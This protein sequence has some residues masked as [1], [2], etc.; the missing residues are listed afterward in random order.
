MS[1]EPELEDDP[2]DWLVHADALQASG[3][4]RGELIAFNHALQSGATDDPRARDAFVRAHAQRLLGP[5]HRWGD[6]L[7]PQ[8]WWTSFSSAR[9]EFEASTRPG[10]VDALL[11]APQA[12]GLERL[13]IIGRA[14]PDKVLKH[15]YGMTRVEQGP[16]LNLAA[17]LE[18]LQQRGLPPGC[19]ELSL[20][21]DK[22]AR[23][24]FV[25][26]TYFDPPE[27]RVQFGDLRWLWPRC[28]QLCGLELVVSD[29]MQVELGTIHAPALEH[30][31]LECLTWNGNEEL[32]DSILNATWPKLRSFALR[33]PER[34]VGNIPDREEAYTRPYQGRKSQWH[35]PDEDG[36][37]LGFDWRP[38]VVALLQNLHSTRLKRLALTSFDSTRGVLAAIH[39]FGLPAGLEELDL[40]DS[41]LG[42]RD[43]EQMIQHEG[44]Y[45]S[46]KRLV[47]KRTSLSSQTA[48]L[49]SLMGPQVLHSQG[50]GAR[51]RFLVGAE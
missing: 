9:L 37:N 33:L 34:W 28:P 44:M 1:L 8:W 48:E 39:E 32:P 20:V 13:E 38:T 14:A 43:A 30:F 49:L 4:P 11:D 35:D 16:T 50:N 21:D 3:D 6:A 19:T 31:R 42:E 7:R 47:L 5:L 15:I 25:I 46:L 12:R 29:G 10:L 40:S 41:S 45:A 27:N 18:A 24:R 17:E 26:E 51:Y 2:E 22:A 23:S 36:S